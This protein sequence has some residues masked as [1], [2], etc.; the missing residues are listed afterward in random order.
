MKKAF[1]RHQAEGANRKFSRVSIP[2]SDAVTVLSFLKE[3]CH[4]FSMCALTCMAGGSRM[5]TGWGKCQKY[6]QCSKNVLIGLIYN[7]Y[8]N[9]LFS[10]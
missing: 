2:A 8:R 3:K 5:G 9:V 1:P 4:E 10:E 6:R 7:F